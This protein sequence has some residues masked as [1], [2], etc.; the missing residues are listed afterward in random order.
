MNPSS[1]Y[2]NS[3]HTDPVPSDAQAVAH[4]S[5]ELKMFPDMAHTDRQRSVAERYPPERTAPT[6]RPS[7]DKL[8]ES[9]QAKRLFTDSPIH[10]DAQQETISTMTELGWTPEDAQAVFDEQAL[11][12]FQAVGANASE[13]AIATQVAMS[14][15]RSEPSAQLVESWVESSR[16]AIAQDWG[17]HRIGEVLQITQEYVN[18]I[19]EARDMLMGALGNHPTMVRMLARKAMDAKRGAR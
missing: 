1:F 18:G 9:E 6:D 7:M 2:P 8:S 11:P 16:A 10:G 15:V 13:S 12:V 14:I 19:P 4:T 17:Q 5:M 3:D